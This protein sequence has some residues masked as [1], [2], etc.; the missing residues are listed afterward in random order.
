MVRLHAAKSG[1]MDFKEVTLPA[2]LNDM[3]FKPNINTKS[4]TTVTPTITGPSAIPSKAPQDSI[5]SATPSSKISGSDDVVST[6]ANFA[7]STGASAEAIGEDACSKTKTET[8][9]ESSSTGTPDPSIPQVSCYMKYNYMYMYI[10]YIY[11]VHV[12]YTLC[13]MLVM[14]LPPTFPFYIARTVHERTL[15]MCHAIIAH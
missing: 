9:K 8:S 4:A 14:I 11:I 1:N 15:Y 12:Q 10:L 7:N 6:D 5:S 3:H 2:E 13:S